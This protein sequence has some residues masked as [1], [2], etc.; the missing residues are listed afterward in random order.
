M[1]R[2]EFELRISR[3]ARRLRIDVSAHRGVVV[4]VPEGT[5][6]D[7]VERFVRARRSWIHRARDEVAAEA[8]S[9]A[10]PD[11]R[12]PARLDLRALDLSYP[13]D[14]VA[15]GRPRVTCAGGRVRVAGRDGES[16]VRAALARWLRGVARRHLVAR[17]HALA[18]CHG[19]SFERVAVRG[20]RSRWASCSGRGTISLNYKLLFLPP[21]LVDHVLLHELA[22][23]RYLDHS[24]RFWRLLAELDPS[25]RTHHAALTRA[26]RWLPA[27][28]EMD[29]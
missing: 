4:V 27:W 13:V 2:G 16:A 26:T 14:V 9:L 28:V 5:P 18:G 23:T 25:W 12:V 22:H 11:E 24:V 7:I 29:H 19:L 15:G 1:T 21:A 3:R 8:A 20:Q 17:L 10:R 6:R